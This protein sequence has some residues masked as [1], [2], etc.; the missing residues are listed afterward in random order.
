MRIFLTIPA[1]LLWV[2]SSS[3][4]AQEQPSDSVPSIGALLRVP[5]ASAS[6]APARPHSY[7]VEPPLTEQLRMGP[8]AA[9][10]VGG[11][12]GAAVGYG[13]MNV[14]CRNR[15]CEMGDLIGLMVGAVVGSGIGYVIAGGQLPPRYNAVA[16]SE[17]SSDRGYPGRAAVVDF[18]SLR[19]GVSEPGLGC[20]ERLAKFELYSQPDK[21]LEKTQGCP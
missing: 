14:A 5:L 19:V 4:G 21:G 11:V 17:A 18:K 7:V 9:A 15:Y 1:T 3:V 16:H 10:L 6:V 2:I 20:G 12:V 8:D 13:L